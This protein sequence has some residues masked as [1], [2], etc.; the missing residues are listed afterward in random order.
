MEIESFI[1]L[2]RTFFVVLWVTLES[3]FCCTTV[4]WVRNHTKFWLWSLRR[5]FSCR[6]GCIKEM[7]GLMSYH[8]CL[9]SPLAVC[10]FFFPFPHYLLN[11]YSKFIKWNKQLCCFIPCMLEYILEYILI[12]STSAVCFDRWDKYC[13]YVV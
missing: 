7:S 10:A 6:L 3:S 9:L 11:I 1:V 13:I 5:L 8:T 2:P 12:Q 4:F